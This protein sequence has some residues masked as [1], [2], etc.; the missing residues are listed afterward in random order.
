MTRMLFSLLSWSCLGLC[1]LEFKGCCAPTFTEVEIRV[2]RGMNWP[3]RGELVLWS[4][5]V[6]DRAAVIA[7][8]RPRRVS[9]IKTSTSE[10]DSLPKGKEMPHGRR[11][12]L[13]ERI[14]KRNLFILC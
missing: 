2:S 5:V 11:E 4:I 10:R 6:F 14:R 8:Q 12:P 13:R 1:S 7:P 9:I 3:R